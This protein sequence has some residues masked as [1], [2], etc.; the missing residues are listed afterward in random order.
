MKMAIKKF[1]KAIE[2]WEPVTKEQV[3][4]IYKY[5]DKCVKVWVLKK[6]N[7]GR[8]KHNIAVMFDKVNNK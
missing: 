6:K 1:R 7:G 4:T 8:K 5:I 2:K 3:S